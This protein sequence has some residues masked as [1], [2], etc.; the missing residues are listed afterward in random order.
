MRRRH[1]VPTGESAC[2][3][4]RL[5][6]GGTRLIAHTSEPVIVNPRM[7]EIVFTAAG[8]T[9]DQSFGNEFARPCEPPANDDRST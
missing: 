3:I 4:D 1:V 7:S 2:R 6:K 8:S 9:A 5:P